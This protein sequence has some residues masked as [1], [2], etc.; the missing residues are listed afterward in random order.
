MNIRPSTT[1]GEDLTTTDWLFGDL[2]V[3]DHFSIVKLLG[4]SANILPL[5]EPMNNSPLLVP[6]VDEVIAGDP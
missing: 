4:S 1:A 3:H 5:Y 6:A 2:S